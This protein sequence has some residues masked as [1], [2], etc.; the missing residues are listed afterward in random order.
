MNDT[1]QTRIEADPG[2]PVA[3]VTIRGLGYKF[4]PPVRPAPG[5]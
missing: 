2:L 4:A 1:V 5:T 3:I